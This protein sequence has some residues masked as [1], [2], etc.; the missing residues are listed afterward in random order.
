MAT[1][2]RPR[3]RAIPFLPLLILAPLFYSIFTT[4]NSDPAEA[5]KVSS[6]VVTVGKHSYSKV[7]RSMA[8]LNTFISFMQVSMPTSNVIILTDPNSKFSLNH[9]SA[10]ILPI[11]GNYT[12]ENLMLQRIRSYIAFLEQRLE[13]LETMEDVYHIIFTDSDIAVVTDLG[14]IFKIYPNCHLALTFRNNK[15]QPL[16][17]GFVAVRGTR[18][19]VSKAVEF[20]KEV[21]E[22]YQLNYMKASRMLGDQL[23]LVWVVKSHLPSAFRKFSKHED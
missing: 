11:E 2:W 13:E 22:A 23:A 19:G 9:G 6:D 20:F 3:S 18:D 4:Y 15:G 5:G 10:A 8:I 16:N 17:S 12:R 14:D 21:L 1:W 7:G